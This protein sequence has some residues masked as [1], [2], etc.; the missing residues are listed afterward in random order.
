MTQLDK[1]RAGEGWRDSALCKGTQVNFYP[2]SGN[3]NLKVRAAVKEAVTTCRV[4]PVRL[5]CLNWAIENREFYGIWGG[6]TERE[7][8]ILIEGY[9]QVAEIVRSTIV[10]IR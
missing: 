1:P 10:E 6:T 8:R 7:R 2:F 3:H 9:D 4:C 5:E